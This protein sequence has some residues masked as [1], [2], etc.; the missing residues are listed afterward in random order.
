M[1]VRSDSENMSELAFVS[2][3]SYHSV[4]APQQSIPV[5]AHVGPGVCH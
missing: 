5:L 1:F 4:V 2:V 3:L